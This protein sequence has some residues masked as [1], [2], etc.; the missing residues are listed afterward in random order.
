MEPLLV[1]KDC[2][3]KAYTLE[4]VQK[5]FVKHKR[6]PL[7]Y[8]NWCKECQNVYRRKWRQDHPESREKDREYARRYRETHHRILFK[9][10]RLQL[11]EDPRT[12]ICFECGFKGD[13]QIHHD[14]YD[15]S[16]PLA[17]TRELCKSCHT[18]EHW[19]NG[20][21]DQRGYYNR[22]TGEHVPP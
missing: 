3:L 19:N 7:G 21:F 9:D 2:G 6:S 11:A 16:D 15:P 8:C 20:S 22:W 5:K 12:G 14:V 10:A 18:K 17:H 4:K 1:C 13:T